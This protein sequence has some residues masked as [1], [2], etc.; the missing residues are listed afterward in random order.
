MCLGHDV[1]KKLFLAD[2]N[3]G[4]SPIGFVKAVRTQRLTQRG[5]D[6]FKSVYPNWLSEFNINY[7]LG[8][9]QGYYKDWLD[10]QNTTTNDFIFRNMEL[11]EPQIKPP[12]RMYKGGQPTVSES[13]QGGAS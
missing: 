12:Q 10:S 9:K 7:N 8:N 5:F 1:D 6:L 4:I 11:Q 13:I 2:V 3:Q